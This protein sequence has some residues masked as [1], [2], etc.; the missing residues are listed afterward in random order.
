MRPHPLLVDSY[1]IGTDSIP[2]CMVNILVIV[3]NCPVTSVHFHPPPYSGPDCQQSAILFRSSMQSVV[4]TLREK[5]SPMEFLPNDQHGPFRDTQFSLG[6]VP[7]CRSKNFAEGVFSFL[8]KR[9]WIR[10]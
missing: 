4:T 2:S 8:F 7:E 10:S 1:V 6:R 5:E 3:C 9:S